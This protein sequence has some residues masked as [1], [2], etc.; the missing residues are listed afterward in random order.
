MKTGPQLEVSSDRLV[1][2]GS[3]PTAL[4]YNAS[5]LSTTLQRFLSLMDL[6]PYY[7]VHKYNRSLEPILGFFSFGFKLPVNCRDGHVGMVS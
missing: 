4:A 6:R 1:K 2:P 7:F 3:E 5:G